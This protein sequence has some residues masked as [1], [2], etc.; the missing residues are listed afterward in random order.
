MI[1]RRRLLAAVLLLATAVSA[2]GQT[3]RPYVETLAS[4]K[5]A[6]REA[7]SPGER[8]A[9]DYIAAQ[10]ARMGAKPLPGR[11]DMFVPFNF[12]AGSRDNGSRV[13]VGSTT[14]NTAKDVIALS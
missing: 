12:S 11:S 14:F 10:L 1:A 6:G 9:G 3:T 8:L 2:A 4:E 5:F 7:G 13:A